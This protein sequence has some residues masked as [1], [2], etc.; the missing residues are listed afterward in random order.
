MKQ[1]YAFT[2]IELMIVVAIIGI[3]SA[4]AVPAYRN[5]IASTQVKMGIMEAKVGV[6]NVDKLMIENS[7]LLGT[8]NPSYV[9]L[10]TSTKY[11]AM[12]VSVQ[13]PLIADSF[14]RCTLKSSN[15]TINGQTVTWTRYGISGFDPD[16]DPYLGG[17]WI[18][19]TTVPLQFKGKCNGH[20]N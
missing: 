11:C 2:L 12:S 18:C 5:Y 15:S 10:N 4:I 17:T 7:S 1:Q 19:D 13:S 14:I 8:T 20:I 6:R 3:L 9:G 16:G